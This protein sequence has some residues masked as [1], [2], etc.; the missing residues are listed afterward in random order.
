[1]ALSIR[2]RIRSI[3]FITFLAS[4]PKPISFAKRLITNTISSPKPFSM[5]LAMPFTFPKAKALMEDISEGISITADSTKKTIKS[6]I[7]IIALMNPPP[8]TSRL[9]NHFTPAIST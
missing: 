6:L 4:P 2:F 8:G 5:T 1:M 3:I 7:D 9:T